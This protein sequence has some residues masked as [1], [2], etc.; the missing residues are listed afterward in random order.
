M[1]DVLSSDEDEI[2]ESG[3]EYLESLHSKDF[4]ALGVT[5]RLEDDTS[6]DE[7]YEPNEET[8]LESYSTPLDEDSCEIDEYVVF[9]EVFQSKNQYFFFIPFFMFLNFINFFFK[10]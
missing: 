1:L 8:A 4:A 5:A 10:F 3:A 9:K 6:D 2:D 7:D